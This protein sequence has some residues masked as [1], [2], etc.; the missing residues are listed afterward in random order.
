[1]TIRK[2]MQNSEIYTIANNLISAFEDLASLSLPVK[3]H[4]YFQKN[5]DSIIAIA[6][7][8]DKARMDIFNK[9]GKLDE[10][11]QNYK[12]EADV[13]EQVNSDVMD[14]F[15]LEQEVKIQQIPLDWLDDVSL[16]AAQVNAMSYM[17]LD[18]EADEEPKLPQGE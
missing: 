18:P 11:G 10:D 16:T 1:M 6:Q 15:S 8:V 14:L 4:F 3:V 17:I 13:V 9:Y 2:N 5:M 7:E 12:F